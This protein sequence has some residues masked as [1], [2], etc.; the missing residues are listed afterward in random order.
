MI[1]DEQ[2]RQTVSS[3]ELCSKTT[4]DSEIAENSSFSLERLINT[5]QGDIILC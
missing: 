2:C 1:T 3:R 5:W 4:K